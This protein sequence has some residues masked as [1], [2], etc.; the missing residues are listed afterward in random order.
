MTRDELIAAVRDAAAKRG[1]TILTK[2]EF[3]AA[4]RTP[5]TRIDTL[6]ASWA[7][8]CAEAGLQPGV[9]GKMS[10]E[11]LFAAMR[12]AFV[13]CGGIV[14]RAA[15]DRRFRHSRSALVRRFGTWVET[16]IAFA[17]WVETSAPDFPYR[18]ELAA[19]VAERRKGRV[20]APRPPRPSR[21]P[22]KDGRDFGD[23]LGWHGL[24]HAPTN[25][26]GVVLAF[27]AAAD[28]L[29]FGIETVGTG[30]PDC[31]AKRRVAPGRWRAV[32]IE[33]EYRSRNFRDHRHD[34]AG[35]DLIV[36]WE[37]DWA[38][39]PVEVLELRSAIA[40]LRGS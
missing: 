28:A 32:R 2:V 30:F 14:T 34:P 5:P 25:E 10:D 11:A 18:E 39:A 3:C 38:E 4:T 15:F 20:L 21:A 29:G 36:C 33:F 31:T 17:A 23:I 7:E 22:R 19:H 1:T 13:A 40:G 16:L 12:D 37:H 35:C 24:F 6:F 8:L 27:G 26:M 9:P